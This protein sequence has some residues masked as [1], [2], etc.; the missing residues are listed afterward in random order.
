MGLKEIWVQKKFR[1]P[2]I[3]GPKILDPKKYESQ[4]KFW[5]KKKLWVHK[6]LSSEKI[7]GLK[8]NFR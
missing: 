6:I 7:S 2:E 5:I 1:V 4:K 8:R 3:L